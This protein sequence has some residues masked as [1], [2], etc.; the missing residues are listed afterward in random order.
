M[1]IL[2]SKQ[3]GPLGQLAKGNLDGF[4]GST[5]GLGRRVEAPEY[6][7]DFAEGMRIEEIVDGRPVEDTAITLVGNFMP[8]G[9]LEFGGTQKIVKEYYPGNAE[10]VVQVM[11]AQEDDVN[12]KGRMRTKRF[13][14]VELRL[15]ADEY[16]RQ[17][18]AIRRRGNL[19][20]VTL[21]EW[22][23]YGIIEK[24]TFKLYRLTDI[25]YD[26]VLS[27]IGL[28]PP[29]NC[30][31]TD[32][33]DDNILAANRELSDAVAEALAEYR[34][35]PDEMPRSLSE[36]LNDQIS[37]VAD[38]IGLVTGFIDGVFQSVENVQ[39]SAARGVG[40][41]KNARA[42]IS[43]YQRRVGAIELS[44]ANLGGSVGISGL[45]SAARYTNMDHITKTLGGFMAFSVMLRKLQEKY[46]ALAAT[47]PY[48]RHLVQDGDNLQRLAMRYYGNQDLWEKIYE[49]NKLTSTTLTSGT[50][51]EIPKA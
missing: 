31:F 19:V 23:R 5:L 14:D 13:K 22:V 36:F 2:D 26:I 41:I 12:L 47:V 33:L 20:R 11:G 17:L 50:V 24:G 45:K 1:G 32:T 46:A 43:N 8:I 34:N 25:E 3:Q 38:A 29:S 37:V 27:V 9:S 51:L 6:G 4:I 18:D 28:N 16:Q 21:G 15:A 35:Y 30:K 7:P 10:P 49:H 48:K 42:K 40:L 44:L 39:A